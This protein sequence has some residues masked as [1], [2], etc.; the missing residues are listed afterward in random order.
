M[1]VNP[2]FNPGDIT[3]DPIVNDVIKKTIER[4]LQG[5]QK[6]GK[7][8]SQN[9]RPTSEWVDETIEEMLDAIHYLT[10]IKAEFK[11]L[12]ADKIKVKAA[13]KGLGE[14]TSTNEKT[15]TQS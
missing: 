3:D 6:F 13:L 4:H 11:E 8:M 9:K 7:P 14:G 2:D 5:M 12:D 1:T 15:E 10:K